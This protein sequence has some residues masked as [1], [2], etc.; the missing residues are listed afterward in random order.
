MAKVL[1]KSKP[2]D[3]KGYIDLDFRDPESWR[4]YYGGNGVTILFGDDEVGPFAFLSAFPPM[5]DQMPVGFAHS[6]PSDNWRISVR[7]TT[8]MG[9][10]V[11]T[12]GQFR[13]HDGGVP[14]A[15]DNVAWGPNG[16]FGLVMF[17]DRRGFPIRPVKASLAEKIT[18]EQESVG[19]K[20]GIEIHD[21]CPG[22][23]AIATTLG[24]TKRA[25]LN[26]GFETAESWAEVAPGIRLNVGL[27][28]ERERGPVIVLVDAAAGAEALP[29]RNLDTEVLV[30]PIYGAVETEGT[31]LDEGSVRLENAATDAVPMIAS[32][33]G[34]QVVAIFGNRQALAEALE[35]G[36]F[37][38][39]EYAAAFG[40]LLSQLE[41]ELQ[42]DHA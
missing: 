20:L 30:L 33:E 12:K 31:T 15:S 34:A 18:P 41:T 7:G 19:E 5:E 16:G 23:P 36:T 11:Y 32:S 25:H 8:N 17:G 2:D 27:L 35:S 37:G 24:G 1:T 42:G 4:P 3:D 10:D 6:H 14:Y 28:G 21:P 29:A 40:Q 9:H 26:G 38:D 39:A 13:Y 22:A